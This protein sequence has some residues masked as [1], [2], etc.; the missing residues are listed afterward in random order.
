MRSARFSFCR[1]CRKSCSIG[2]WWRYLYSFDNCAGTIPHYIAHHFPNAQIDIVEINPIVAQLQMEYFDFDIYNN[3]NIQ[4]H[5][6]DGTQFLMNSK[7]RFDFIV[8][9]GGAL[10]QLS[11]DEEIHN[12]VA[13]LDTR[14]AVVINNF[15]ANDWNR[16]KLAKLQKYFEEVYIL[17]TNTVNTVFIA[18]NFKSELGKKELAAKAKEFSQ[19]LKTSVKLDEL[20]D[21]KKYV[22]HFYSLAGISKC[23]E[24]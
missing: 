17:E 24:L 12:L 14:G 6:M 5:V 19:N 22:K 16:N 10:M 4:V 1:S 2:S 21:A 9:D 20:V 15:Y 13:K 3:E 7:E 18:L 11:N 8:V 23:N